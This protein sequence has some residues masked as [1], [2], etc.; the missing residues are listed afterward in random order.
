MTVQLTSLLG[1]KS[2]NMVDEGELGNVVLELNS[3]EIFQVRI[4]MLGRS[5]PSAAL[6]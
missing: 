1:S 5:L 2:L 6:Q 3:C 4:I